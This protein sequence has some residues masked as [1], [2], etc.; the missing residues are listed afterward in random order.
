MFFR[1]HELMKLSERNVKLADRVVELEK[2]IKDH[3]SEVAVAARN[4]LNTSAFAIDFNR[5]KVFAIER[6]VNSNNQAYTVVGHFVDEPVAFTDGNCAMKSVVHEYT[7]YCSQAEH[8]RLVKEFN[9][10][11]K[12]SK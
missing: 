11:K 3:N 10:F 7:F 8:E 2:C 1:S 9:E 6:N 5:M 12:K 4:D